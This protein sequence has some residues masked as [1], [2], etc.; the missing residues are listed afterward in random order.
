MGPA[1]A[2]AH[3]TGDLRLPLL[4]LLLLPICCSHAPPGWRFTSSEVV[5][6][7][8]VSHRVG[9]TGMQGQ[10]SYKIRLSGQRHVVHMRVKKNLLPRHFPV[11]TSND[12][13]ATQED[14]PF[15]PRDCYY[16]TYLEGVPGSMGTLDTCY[17]GLRG[18]L[19]VDDFTYEIKP[20]EA[21][22]KFEHV[23]SLLVSQ[24]TPGEDEKLK[25]IAAGGVI[26]LNLEVFAETLLAFVIYQNTAVG[27]RTFVQ[28]TLISRMEPPVHH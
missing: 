22:S 19:Q 5:I 21:S 8:K 17:G 4:W 23:I 27:R 26:M 16:Y 13:G 24:K 6:P 14:Y 7:R 28:Q 20:L 2:Q 11:I 10:L 15:I 1:W 18:M 25:E 12:Q 9:G 3:L